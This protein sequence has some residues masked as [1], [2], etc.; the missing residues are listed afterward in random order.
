MANGETSHESSKKFLLN[1]K[2]GVCEQADILLA[3]DI[4]KRISALESLSKSAQFS[5]ESIEEVRKCSVV[6]GDIATTNTYLQDCFAIL[7][8]LMREFID[9][10]LLLRTWVT[11]L[12]PKTEDGDNLGVQLQYETVNTCD[13]CSVDVQRLYYYINGYYVERARLLSKFEKY[14]SKAHACVRTSIEEYDEATFIKFSLSISQ[15]Y[16]FYLSMYDKIMKNIDKIKKP[17]NDSHEL[18]F[19]W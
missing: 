16:Y 19:T 6:D 5:W 7:K 1:H 17:R 11:M 18:Y 15:L 10:S 4:P 8:P 13:D 12:V 14:G 2:T 9:N 3:T